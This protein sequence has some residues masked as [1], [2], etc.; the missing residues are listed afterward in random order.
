MYSSTV[1][2]RRLPIPLLKSGSKKHPLSVSYSKNANCNDNLVKGSASEGIY[3]TILVNCLIPGLQVQ[4]VFGL[5]QSKLFFSW[6]LRM[7]QL[8]WYIYYTWSTKLEIYLSV[9]LSR[10][11]GYSLTWVGIL[12]WLKKKQQ[13]CPWLF[14]KR[15]A[16]AKTKVS[17]QWDISS[18]FSILSHSQQQYSNTKEHIQCVYKHLRCLVVAFW[19]SVEYCSST[20]HSD[21]TS[22]HPGWEP[23]AEIEHCPLTCGGTVRRAQLSST[24]DR[25]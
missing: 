5:L 20:S 23:P 19:S 9:L 2:K 13:H 25:F 14:L 11:V 24:E 6:Y 1:P 10:N 16:N 17:Q 3:P 7:N 12:S 18:Y 21:H 8:R 22:H 15:K 4:T